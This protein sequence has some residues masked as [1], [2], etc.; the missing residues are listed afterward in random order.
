MFALQKT[1]PVVQYRRWFGVLIYKESVIAGR[2]GGMVKT[3]MRVF[4]SLPRMLRKFVLCPLDI[5]VV[6]RSF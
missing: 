1:S 5:V 4:G 6:S 3:P 2:N